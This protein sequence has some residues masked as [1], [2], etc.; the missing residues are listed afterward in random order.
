[1][2]KIVLIFLVIFIIIVTAN[3]SVSAQRDV[4]MSIKKHLLVIEENKGEFPKGEKL[5]FYQDLI[6]F[7]QQRY[8]RPIWLQNK[9]FLSKS[10]KLITLIKKS[11]DDGLTPADYHLDLIEAYTIK[12]NFSAKIN[13]NSLA[14]NS[15][16]QKAFL[17]ILLSSAYLKLASHYLNGKVEAGLM[18]DSYQQEELGAQRLLSSIVSNRKNINEIIKSQLPQSK[19]YQLLKEKLSLYR[20]SNKIKKWPQVSNGKNLTLGQR[21]KRV[22]DLIDNLTART[23]LNKNNLQQENYFSENVKKAVVKFQIDN[24][25]KNDG[26]VG[27][28]TITALNISLANRIKQLIINLER[29]RWLPKNLGEK[30]IYVNVADYSLQLYEKGNLMMN[31]KTIVGRQDRS[32][33]VFSDKIDYLV[34][35]PYWYVP[36][37]IAVEDILPKLKEDYSYLKKNNFSLLQYNSNNKLIE[38][39]P[40]KINWEEIDKDSFNYLLRQNPGAGNSLGKIKF[41]FPNKFS[42]YLHDTPA[43]YLFSQNQRSFSSGCIRIEKPIDLAENLL[44]DHEKWDRATI[45]QEMKKN[46]EKKIYLK[47]PIKIYIQYNSSWVDSFGNLHFREDIYDRDQKIIEK[48]F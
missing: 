16:D 42:V 3:L 21:G 34:L 28:K 17:D 26:V 24:G 48:Y 25:L 9:E 15:T 46:K 8:Y 32:T 18:T 19:N 37:V 4:S 6:K 38:K 11:Y 10:E 36:K 27:P 12:N 40:A 13:N 23:Y 41:M 5:T 44:K 47:E 43:K 2:K 22:K 29:W 45:K 14:K 30:Y 33:P 20:N 39:D 1:M 35:N 7:Y 31:M